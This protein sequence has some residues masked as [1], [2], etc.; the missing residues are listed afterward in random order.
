MV[1]YLNQGFTNFSLYNHK[2]KFNN[3]NASPIFFN[4]NKNLKLESLA[5][6]EDELYSVLAMTCV[7]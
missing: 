1:N 4:L 7:N 3:F 5:D 2:K 6:S